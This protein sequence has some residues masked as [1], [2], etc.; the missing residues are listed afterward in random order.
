MHTKKEV[1]GDHSRL[2]QKGNAIKST[3]FELSDSLV[4][5]ANQLE[6]EAREEA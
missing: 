2:F 6:T 1:D 3:S 5:M 4:R